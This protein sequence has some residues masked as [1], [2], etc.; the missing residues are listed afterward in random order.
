MQCIQILR[1]IRKE[2]YLIY[3]YNLKMILKD[4]K[5]DT[6]YYDLTKAY[7]SEEEYDMIESTKERL[8]RIQD[9]EKDMALLTNV[10]KDMFEIIDAQQE[11]IDTL[12]A[13]MIST[14]DYAK[15]AY[16]EIKKAEEYQE[17]ADYYKYVL[18]VLGTVIGSVMIL[19]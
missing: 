16:K 13:H 7:H 11:G 14:R 10:Y 9:I 4:K 5:S 19:K 6:E 3:K 12:E 1:R 17:S 18:L 2:K 15:T 8:K